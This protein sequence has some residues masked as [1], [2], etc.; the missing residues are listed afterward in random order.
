[1]CLPSYP[2]LQQA[3]SEFIAPSIHVRFS[4]SPLGCLVQLTLD[5]AVLGFLSLSVPNH[6]LYPF[7]CTMRTNRIPTSARLANLRRFLV[8]ISLLASPQAPPQYQR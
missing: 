5:Q 1:M 3:P 6:I 2:V 4:L 8:Q 7:L